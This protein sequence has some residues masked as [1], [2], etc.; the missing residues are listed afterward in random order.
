VA[1]VFVPVVLVIAVVVVVIVVVIVDT[2][3]S[4]LGLRMIK[5]EGERERRR[6]IFG[7]L[8]K[9]FPFFISPKSLKAK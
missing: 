3:I 7:N 4:F 8:I 5:S 1:V 9:F 2:L 6:T